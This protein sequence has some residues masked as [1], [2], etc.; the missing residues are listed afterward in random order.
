MQIAPVQYQ[1]RRADFDYLI[2]HRVRPTG[3]VDR[4]HVG[5]DFTI[6]A[7]HHD[8]STSH[9]WLDAAQSEDF[10]HALSSLIETP[11]DPAPKNAHPLSLD[12]ELGWRGRS[13]RLHALQ[14]PEDEAVSGVLQ[15]AAAA[16]S[17]NPGDIMHARRFP[18]T[19]AD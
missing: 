7:V 11:P 5:P 16:F 15:F 8:G 17:K 3:R 14:L 19:T 6:R 9:Y 13:I 2:I 4:L 18:A 12:I 1:N 10:L